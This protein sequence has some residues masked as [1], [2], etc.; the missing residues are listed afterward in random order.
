LPACIFELGQT[1]LARRKL[2]LQRVYGR[3]HGLPRTGPRDDR[4]WQET[5]RATG[6]T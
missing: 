1:R 3:D 6:P 2:G 5:R 4:D